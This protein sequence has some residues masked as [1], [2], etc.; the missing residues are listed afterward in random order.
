MLALSPM[1]D[2][3]FAF[4]QLLKQPPRSGTGVSPVCRLLDSHGRDARATT[5]PPGALNRKV[6]EMLDG[7]LCRATPRICHK[8]DG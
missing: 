7:R 5:P 6:R 4:R 1:N 8:G 3:K 2:L